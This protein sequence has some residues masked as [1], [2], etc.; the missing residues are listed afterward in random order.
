MA[1]NSEGIRLVKF[2]E[3]LYLKAYID[4][5][6]VL[7]IGYGHTGPDV[8]EGQVISEQQAEDLLVKDLA[9]HEAF[10]E[11]VVTVPLN[12]NQR[13]AL[14]SFAFNVGN[15]SLRDSTLLKK[16]NAGD[17][18]GASNEFTR[19][20]HGT[21]NG[22]KTVLPGLVKRRASERAL[23]RGEPVQLGNERMVISTEGDTD[24]DV[25]VPLAAVAG[26][27]GEGGYDTAFAAYIQSLGLKNFKP[28][29]FLVMGSQNANPQSAAF[30]LNKK[31]PQALWSNIA[32]TAKVIDRLRDVMGA[33]IATLSVYRSPAYN[34]AIAGAGASQHMEFRAI[35]FV[36][37]SNSGPADW[38]SALR[39][40]RGEG[41][42]AGG[43]GTY[44]SFVHVDTRGQNVD[45]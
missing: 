45:W 18:E 6:G 36:V 11:G 44:A 9:H 2:Y 12:D 28:Y 13:A 14:T 19:W 35:D 29:E 17:V 37:K 4:P 22:V 26:A 41:L 31:P 33:P 15:G 1:I 42:F 3:G 5:V 23:F 7:T 27:N 40:M 39:Q 10:V 30:G 34:K 24:D 8:F 32:P 20:V 16:L 38:A 21:V 25:A 43:I